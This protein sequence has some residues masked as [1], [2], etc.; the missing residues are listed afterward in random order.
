M[1]ASSVPSR[2]LLAAASR[3]RREVDLDDVDELPSRPE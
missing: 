3:Q 2:E 1:N